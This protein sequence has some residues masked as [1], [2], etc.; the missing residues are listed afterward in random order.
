LTYIKFFYNLGVH[1]GHRGQLNNSLIYSRLL[2]MYKGRAIINVLYT[3]MY[4]RKVLSF[5]KNNNFKM[6]FHISSLFLHLNLERMSFIYLIYF[7]Y[8]HSIADEFWFSGYFDKVN[9][10]LSIF[11]YLYYNYNLKLIKFGFVDFL[12]KIM[13]FI[14][15]KRT[16]TLTW[17]EYF[18]KAE[19]YWKIFILYKLVRSYLRL[20]DC[21]IFLNSLSL[22]SPKREMNNLKVPVIGTL[23]SDMKEDNITY[24]IIC[25]DKNLIFLLFLCKIILSTS[26]M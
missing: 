20:P 5:L 2:G 7:K 22:N 17:E 19:I 26:Q 21:F 11:L 16:F 12:I 9:N 23:D 4:I 10:L 18:N 25:N 24:P 6:L 13:F 3:N 1:L 14:R 8:N 15:K